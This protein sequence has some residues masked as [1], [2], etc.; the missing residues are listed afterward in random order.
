MTTERYEKKKMINITTG[1]SDINK[2][3]YAE[4]K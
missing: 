1:F 4:N 2:K 3:N